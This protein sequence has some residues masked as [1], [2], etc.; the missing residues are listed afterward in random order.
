LC[1]QLANYLLFLIYC[2]PTLKHNAGTARFAMLLPRRCTRLRRI[3]QSPLPFRHTLPHRPFTAA[4]N[5]E[6]GRHPVVVHGRLYLR[7]EDKRPCY[8][9]RAG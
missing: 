1:L 7:A 4:G 2:P 3:S 6:I 8:N 9:V 5:D